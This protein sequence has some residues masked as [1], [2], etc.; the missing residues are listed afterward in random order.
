M[1][2][3]WIHWVFPQGYEYKELLSDFN[4]VGQGLKIYAA[5]STTQDGVDPL[6]EVLG[7]RLQTI[8]GL[9]R[10]AV[11]S[12]G[13]DEAQTA[14]HDEP[15]D[16]TVND[17]DAGSNAGS[18]EFTKAPSG[19]VDHTVQLVPVSVTSE[20][21]FIPVL[22]RKKKPTLTAKMS[23]A[24]SALSTKNVSFARTNG[25]DAKKKKKG[26]SVTST[27]YTSL[28]LDYD[29]ADYLSVKRYQPRPC[30]RFYLT[31]GCKN[32]PKCHYGHDYEVRK[33]RNVSV[34]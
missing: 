9:F 10:S 15:E 22:S 2:G 19:I 16:G 21:D 33:M 5:R 32:G 25:T 12:E 1:S 6:D 31:N 20:D 13:A 17:S 4:A 27:Q 26:K 18:I 24:S 23:Y 34:I 3:M 11:V 14:E 28:A 7:T 30:H 29:H 8:P